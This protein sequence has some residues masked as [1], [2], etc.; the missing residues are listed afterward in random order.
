MSSLH[1][2]SCRLP[3]Q[4]L[5]IFI[6][7]ALQHF[8][9]FEFTAPGHTAA[10]T[11]TSLSG[12]QRSGNEHL[13]LS[14]IAQGDHG[15]TARELTK[16][17]TPRSS[18]HQGTHLAGR[19]PVARLLGEAGRHQ[20]AQLRRPV[21]RVRPPVPISHLQS[22][23][24][25]DERPSKFILIHTLEESIRTCP[26]THGTRGM[27][28]WNRIPSASAETANIRQ[29]GGRAHVRFAP[30]LTPL[31]APCC[32]HGWWFSCNPHK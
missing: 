13:S 12:H 24:S 4:H 27:K 25:H 15:K 14:Q 3:Q 22:S 21:A 30:L 10:R 29:R 1:A 11:Y 31:L 2:S 16:Q 5:L 8:L 28:G 32:V 18:I 20:G 7:A 17:C 9:L 23:I 19:R 6:N 26:K